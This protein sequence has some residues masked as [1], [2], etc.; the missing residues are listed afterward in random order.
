MI[1]SRV[2]RGKKFYYV[3]HEVK[4]SNFEICKRYTVCSGKKNKTVNNREIC[5]R[6]LAGSVENWP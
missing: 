4:L 3:V 1:G 5:K 6:H 2:F